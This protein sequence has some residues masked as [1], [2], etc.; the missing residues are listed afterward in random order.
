MD[1]DNNKRQVEGWVRSKNEREG[2]GLTEREIQ[3]AAIIGAEAWKGQVGV[4][5]AAETGINS[6]K[7]LR[8]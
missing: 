1:D 4:G 3:K 2:H 8:E 7:K 5:H 6:V